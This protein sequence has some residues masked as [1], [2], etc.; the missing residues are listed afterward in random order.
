MMC[1]QRCIKAVGEVSALNKTER[2]SKNYWIKDA[3]LQTTREIL[4]EDLNYEVILYIY[5][6]I[7][8]CIKKQ[9]KVVIYDNYR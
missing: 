6:S 7:E 5:I 8:K 9:R 4:P 1:L 2:G 3:L